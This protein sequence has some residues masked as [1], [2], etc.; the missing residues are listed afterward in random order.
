MIQR[1]PPRARELGILLLAGTLLFV[2]SL[3]NVPA[4]RY[5]LMLLLA[6]TLLATTPRRQWLASARAHSRQLVPLAVLSLWLVLQA[7]LISPETSWALKELKSQWLN[8]LIA[9]AIGLALAEQCA[10]PGQWLTSQKVSAMLICAFAIQAAIGSVQALQ[11]YVKLGYLTQHMPITGGKLEMSYVVNIM[12]GMCAVDLLSGLLGKPTLTRLPRAVVIGILALGM[13][14]SFLAAAR[15][16]MIG[17]IFLTIACTSLFALHHR[18]Q[19]GPRKIL[20]AVVASGLLVGLLAYANLHADPRWSSFTE[21][22]VVAWDIDTNTAWADTRKHSLPMLSTGRRADPS[23]YLRI[24]F[25]HVGLREIEQHPLGVGYGRNAFAH[26]VIRTMPTNVGHAHSGM[27]DLTLGG[28]IPALLL[29]LGWIVSLGVLGWRA[30]VSRRSPHALMLML[31]LSGYTGRMV[32]DSVNRD[33]M[34]QIF[35]FLVGYLMVTARKEA[36]PVHA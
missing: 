35:F 30:Y 15:N 5:T 16:G 19:L 28:G 1:P 21:T 34:L 18:E 12:L 20:S 29:W 27:I 6:T 2:W 17:T 33:H 22:A 36:E 13:L 10:R 24:A 23:A 8:A 25:I 7:L 32:L 31:L 26:A 14:T 4:L 3:P 9:G 11:L